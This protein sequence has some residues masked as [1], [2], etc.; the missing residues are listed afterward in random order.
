MDNGGA[1]AAGGGGPELL[2]VGYERVRTRSRCSIGAP[3]PVIGDDWRS[4]SVPFREKLR[5][6][7]ENQIMVD[8]TFHLYEP[9][10]AGDEAPPE[11]RSAVTNGHGGP[12]DS[13][14][15]SDSDSESADGPALVVG[16]H[17]LVLG[18]ASA[19]FQSTLYGGQPPERPVV[20]RDCD[21]GTFKLMIE[22][23]Y[24]GEC[25]IASVEKARDIFHIGRAY[26]CADL[27]RYISQFVADAVRS[28]RFTPLTC[29]NLFFFLE[30]SREVADSELTQLC[31]GYVDQYAARIIGTPD[32]S[33]LSKDM[34]ATILDRETFDVGDELVVF[35]AVK[36]WGEHQLRAA[37]QRAQ[38]ETLRQTCADLLPFVHMDRIDESDFVKTVLPSGLVGPQELISF[39]MVRGIEIPRN[40]DLGDNQSACRMLM[41]PHRRRP[42]PHERC[43]RYRAGYK[44]A[45]DDM[46]ALHELR[47]RA[48]KDLQLVG[49]HLGY[50]FSQMEL[51]LTVRVQGP[52]ER[53]QWTDAFSQYHR[54]SGDCVGAAPADMR[55]LFHQPVA[56]E[57]GC[58]YKVTVK[59]DRW[60]Y[61]QSDFNIWGGQSG[62]SRVRTDDGR[63]FYFLQAAI[64]K[65]RDI[66]FADM[67]QCRG[68]ITELLYKPV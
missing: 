66:R 11:R 58:C 7:Y 34:V 10:A 53:V 30:F 56:V 23:I 48:D 54:V 63:H 21:P 35:L 67:K 22:F 29:G 61:T 27:V 2:T 55:V 36:R 14:S 60:K 52:F 9:Q 8:V 31:W 17:R 57:G 3:S 43:L 1:E 39:F 51:G 41:E 4:A 46:E 62:P 13:D 6:L 47:F 16:A 25:I 42:P 59:V 28:Y 65:G 45:R 20:V 49:L 5:Y 26:Q 38:H 32:F 37:G 64:E 68:L 12:S 24:S 40:I 19:V 50:I 18:M 44:L 33:G 15:D